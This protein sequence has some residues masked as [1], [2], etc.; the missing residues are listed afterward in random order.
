MKKIYAV[1][2]SL[3]LTITMTYFTN[4]TCVN[5]N[6]QGYFV[7]VARINKHDNDV[8]EEIP[9]YVDYLSSLSCLSITYY[10]NLGNMMVTI[11]ALLNDGGEEYSECIINA[12]PNSAV[13]PI[14]GEPGYYT[15]TYTILSTGAEYIS[16][17]QL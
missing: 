9:F 7:Q 2:S 6:F 8:I 3:I 5:E 10:S 13:I 12:Y 15:I 11:S 4:A 1:L 14:S 17:F 16:T